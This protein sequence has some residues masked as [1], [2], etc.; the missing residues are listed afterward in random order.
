MIDRSRTDDG[1]SFHPRCC[2]LQFAHI[3]RRTRAGDIPQAKA[4]SPAKEQSLHIAPLMNFA[5][6]EF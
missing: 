1:D 5:V 6:M 3:A 4:K 2:P